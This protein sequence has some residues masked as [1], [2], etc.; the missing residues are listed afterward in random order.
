VHHV[1]VLHDVVLA[2]DAQ[3]AGVLDR[4]LAAELR[5]RLVAD[6]LRAD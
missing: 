2:L 6:R 1:A 4:L 3:L 5:V